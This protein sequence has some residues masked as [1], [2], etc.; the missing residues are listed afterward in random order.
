MSAN[1][2][3]AGAAPGLA[4]TPRTRRLL[5]AM[6]PVVLLA[7]ARVVTHADGLTAAGTF[8]A[9]IGLAAPVA[10]TGLGGLVSERSG[11]VNIGLEGMMILGTVFAGWFGWHGGPWAALLGGV[12]GGTLGGALH[13]TATIKFGVDHTVSGVAI[14]L[15]ARGIAR[16]LSSVLFAGKGG[17]G[18]LTSSPSMTGMNHFTLPI[19]SGGRIGSW[20]TPDVLGRIESKRWFLVS[21]LG[22][23]L[24]GL[25]ADVAGSTILLYALIPIF[26]YIIWRTPWGL[27][28][29]SCGEKPDA[30]DSLGI[31]VHRTQWTAVL[32][33]GALAGLGGAW[34]A[35]DV[36]KYQQGQ[37]ASRGFLALAAVVF[38]NWRPA[39]LVAGALLFYFPEAVRLATFGDE[40]KGIL[41]IAAIAFALLAL[42]SFRQRKLTEGLVVAAAGAAVRFWFNVANKVDE[43]IVVTFPFV[44]V[45]LVLV[46]SSQRL[47]P[48]AS[49][50]QIW[51]KGS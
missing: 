47:R 37:T 17:D 35:I 22:G 49:S 46:F 6:L 20:Q 19:L 10:V 16:Y 39:G 32:L 26:A 33:S 28:L 48:P 12:V 36:V 44:I 4:I 11:I 18:S 23:I 8:A 43:K 45:L 51:R 41:L 25:T 5:L 1:A 21:D 15:M 9:A 3:A 13:A 14:N 7:T 27:R 40:P 50:G 31:N 34:L 38:A 30:A 24:K 2:A 29:R 42:W